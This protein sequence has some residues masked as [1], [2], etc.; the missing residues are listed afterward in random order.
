MHE[1]EKMRVRMSSKPMIT[2][3]VRVRKNMLDKGGPG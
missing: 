3:E 2:I 1:Y